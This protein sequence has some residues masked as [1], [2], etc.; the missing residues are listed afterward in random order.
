MVSARS[1]R[2]IR[3]CAREAILCAL[4]VSTWGG[5]CIA[6]LTSAQAI[7]YVRKLAPSSLDTLLP[8]GHLSEWLQ[9]LPG[10]QDTVAWEMNDCGEQ[11]GNPAVDSL[12]DIPVCVGITAHLSDGRELG[13]MI[14]VGTVKRGLTD[15]PGV[16]N[17]YLLDHG[18][19]RTI[20]RLSEIPHIVST[21]QRREERGQLDSARAKISL[22]D[23]MAKGLLGVAAIDLSN[24]DTLTHHGDAHFPMQSVY[25]LPVA[26]AVLDRVD[27]G[28]MSLAQTIHVPRADLRPDTWSPLRQLYPAGDV[29]LPLDTLLKYTVSYSDN[30]GCDILFHLL[31][32]TS[33]VNRYVHALG[34]DN[35]SIVATEFEMAQG[36]DVQYRN[37]SSPRAMA[38]LLKSFHNGKLLSERSQRFLWE[39][40]INTNTGPNR[41]KGLL[42]AGTVVGHKT[43]SSGVDDH[44]RAA[45]TNDVGIVVLPDGRS[46]ALAVFLSDSEASEEQR[47][48]V[49]ASVARAVWNACV[50]P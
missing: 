15:S 9:E 25:K 18:K 23:R 36:A 33:V 14:A 20:R 21:P 3:R 45:A 50:G 7:D 26:L 35:I 31:G 27:K 2:S 34:F 13:I 6:Q 22:I 8:G 4:I 10:I 42:P 1:S 24:G 19:Y 29:D 5:T 38:E 39:L 17:I 40:L 30:N 12:R 48:N 16:Y 28:T 43:G 41:I 11:T 47:D 46:I 44:G 49:I 37:W 32:G